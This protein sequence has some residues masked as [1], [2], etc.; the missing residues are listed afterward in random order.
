MK[1]SFTPHSFALGLLSALGLLGVA[2]FVQAGFEKGALRVYLDPLPSSIVR[3]TEGQPWVVPAG[4]ILMLKS[5]GDANGSSLSAIRLRID[6]KPA[7][8]VQLS[9]PSPAVLGFPV[10]AGP[11]QLVTVE[12]TF[13]SEETIAFADGYLSL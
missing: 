13:P 1:N 7:V 10:T 4:R 2:S 11:G 8:T 12:E 9:G 5:L 3:V 6:G